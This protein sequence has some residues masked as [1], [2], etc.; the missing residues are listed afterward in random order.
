LKVPFRTAAVI[1]LAAGLALPAAAHAKTKTVR[2]GPPAATAKTLQASATDANAYFPSTVTINVGDTVKFEPGGF[3]TAD[4]PK[5]GDGMLP[6]L[7]PNGS[8]VAGS[9]DA[10]GAAFWFNG[11]DNVG[12]N[13]ELLASN[14]GKKLT[15]TGA[16]RIESGLPLA[17]KPKPMSVK[18]TKAGSYTVYCDI[19]PGMKGTVKVLKKGAKVPT[20]AQDKAAV[21]KQAAAAVKNAKGLA[22]ASQPANTVSVGVAAKGGL[23][24]F[25]MVPANLNVARGTTVKF[26]MSKGTYEAHTATF[27]PGDP[28][29]EPQSYLGTIAASFAGAPVIDPRGVYPSEQPG[30]IASLS[31]TLHGNGFWNSGGLDRDSA[32]PLPDS[33]SVKFDTAGTFTYYCVIHPFMRGTVTVT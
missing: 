14:F 6:L 30:T 5:K 2:M 13:P 12:F 15:Y 8:K 7:G 3:H 10:A 28:E 29:K 27:G 24:Y 1:S 9:T 18:F 26:Q 25:G 4:I 17:P 33:A 16:K 31:P 11:Q 23:E 21:R 19:H 32:S 22:T 20:A